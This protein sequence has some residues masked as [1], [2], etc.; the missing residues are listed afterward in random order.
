[1]KI[2][3]T[4]DKKI[5]KKAYARAA[6][7]HHPEDDPEGFQKVK[8]AYEQ[9]LSYAE[10]ESYWQDE[11]AEEFSESESEKKERV[12]DDSGLDFTATAISHR[13]LQQQKLEPEQS[14]QVF[15][16]QELLHRE[17][18]A[19]DQQEEEDS[20][21]KG[22]DFSAIPHRNPQQ[23]KP[24]LEQ[25]EQV[26]PFQELLHREDQTNDQQEEEDSADEGLDFSAILHRNPQQQK[27][28][29][30]QSEQE[31]PFQEL[32]HRE[33]QTNDQQ[34]EEDSANE[35]LDFSA[36][37]NREKPDAE[38]TEKIY[39]FDK[40]IEQGNQE[41]QELLARVMGEAT[42]IYYDKQR[43]NFRRWRAYFMSQ[44]F[45]S[46]QK[47]EAF[48]EK[49]LAFFSVHQDFNKRLWQKVFIPVF[50]EW[51]FIWAGSKYEGTFVRLVDRSA[52]NSNQR[53]GWEFTGTPRQKVVAALL[54]ISVFLFVLYCTFSSLPNKRSSKTL[55]PYS[56][57]FSSQKAIPAETLDRYTALLRIADGISQGKTYSQMADDCS[58]AKVTESQYQNLVALF[59]K[60][61]A[62][63]FR[64]QMRAYAD[65]ALKENNL[66]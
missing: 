52:Q 38:Q 43:N 48:T 19:N 18:Q 8:E 50:R 37:S 39:E 57:S 63:A 49:F 42:K 31:F 66:N 4:N 56:Y 40:Y 9:A 1:M 7:L 13:N 6:K 10:R 61:G 35:E 30:E 55:Q 17:D 2:D 24:E 3:P 23:Q 14:E 16:F 11:K 5:I 47:D 12:P 25:S 26:F 53:S 36:V 51:L 46:L 28:E 34:E 20:A 45:R 22:L 54:G 58:T 27:L 59:E 21:D 41:K 44:D 29:L 33:D 32:L 60:E 64:K 62:T 65:K 15:P